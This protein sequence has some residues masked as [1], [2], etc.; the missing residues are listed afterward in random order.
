MEHAGFKVICGAFMAYSMLAVNSQMEHNTKVRDLIIKQT[1][2]IQEI[3]QTIKNK[4]T[5]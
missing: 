3:Q 2:Q 1:N 4:T 5:R